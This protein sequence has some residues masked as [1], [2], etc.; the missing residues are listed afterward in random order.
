[1]ADFID[2]GVRGVRQDWR[3][4]LPASVVLEA[5]ENRRDHHEQR[6]AWWKGQQE[7]SEKDLRANGAELR[8]QQ[9]TGGARLQMVLDPSRSARVEECRNKV[10]AHARSIAEYSAFVRALELLSESGDKS[11]EVGVGDIQY[12]G[13]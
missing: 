8:E 3:L 12:F 5:A 6:E 7:D 4:R 2:I 9:I 10:A 13:L 11:V 1:M